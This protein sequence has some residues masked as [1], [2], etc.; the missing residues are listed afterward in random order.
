MV[1]FR[2]SIVFMLAAGGVLTEAFTTKETNRPQ[3]SFRRIRHPRDI[4]TRDVKLLL[5]SSSSSEE[6]EKR[7]EMVRQLQNT[8][9]LT[10]DEEGESTPSST[11]SS[12]SPRLEESTGRMLNL[13]LWR[14]GWVEVPGRSNCLN[15]HEGHYTNMFEKIIRDENNPNNYFGHLHLPGGTKASRTGQTRF[16]LKTWQEEIQDDSRFDKKERSAVIGCLMRITDYRRLNDGRLVLLVQAIERFVVDT[17]VEAFPNGLAHVQLLPDIEDT[18]VL[19]S[20]KGK[21][22]EN[23]GKF[24]RAKA[25]RQAMQYHDYE[26]D[27]IKLPLPENAEYMSAQDVFGSKIAKCLPFCFYNQDDSMLEDIAGIKEEEEN[28][29]LSNTPPTSTSPTSFS[30]GQPLLEYQLMADLILR[31]PPPLTGVT[32]RKTNDI[33]AL[34]KLLWLALE[35]CCRN[36]QFTLPPEVLCLMPPDMDYLA[37]EASQ[38]PL[39]DKY[40]A[41]RRQRRLSFSVPGLIENTPVGSAIVTRQLLLNAPGTRSRLLAVLER[42]EYLN[43]A[44]LGQFE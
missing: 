23:F 32:R 36:Y 17:V 2:C 42:L 38:H 18:I 12:S 35:D 10:T 4:K 29:N 14:V 31:D 28:E 43:N 26:C 15:V 22:D 44:V 7:M 34:E 41:R 30:G 21:D 33:D 19:S 20:T 8:F 16:E 13:P 6:E 37:I 27:P 24:R 25:I 9:Y 3:K 1:I 11:A 5:A 40:P 39:S